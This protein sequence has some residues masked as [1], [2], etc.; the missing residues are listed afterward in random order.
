MARGFLPRQITSESAIG[1]ST[2]QKSIVIDDSHLSMTPAS[3]GN[4][5]VWTFSC[6]VKRMQLGA[7]SSMFSGGV[8]GGGAVDYF[9]FWNDDTLCFTNYNSSSYDIRTNAFFRDPTGWMHLVL[10][11]DSTQGTASNR[12]KIYVNGSQMTS[13][14]DSTYPSQNYDFEINKAVT[15]KIGYNHYNYLN[16][17]IAEVNF[18]DGLQLTP[19]SF[20]YESFQT[21]AWRPK[22]YEGAYGSNGYHLNFSDN[23]GVT[24]TTLGKDRSGQGNDFTST[25]IATRDSRLDSPSNN[26]CTFN[27]I[28]VNV[29]NIGTYE[30]G[31]L[32]VSMPSGNNHMRTDSTM[33]PSS[34][35]WYVELTFVSGYNS[36]D[37]TT[38]VGV[39]SGNASRA[40]S[41][42]DG[43]NQNNHNN[44]VAVCYQSGGVIKTQANSNILT[45]LPTF[46][47]GDILGIALDL[48]NDKFFCSKN[49]TFFSN[50]TG[51]Q[52]PVTGANPLYSGGVITSH[53]YNGFNIGIKGYSNQ[54]MKANYGADSTFSGTTTAGGFKD[55]G[56]IGD[57]KY[58]VPAGFKAICSNNFSPG[59]SGGVYNPK[60]HFNVIKYAGDGTQVVRGV[61]FEPGLVW[62]KNMN[63][64]H[65]HQWH[66]INRGPTGG[67]IRSNSSLSAGSSYL[68]DSFDP[69]GFTTASGNIT[70]VN[71]SGNDFTAACWKAGGAPVTNS[72]GTVSGSVSANPE[73]GFSIVKYTGSGGHV[74][75]GHGLGRKPK[76]I[77]SKKTNASG[78][79][80][81]NLDD[82]A[83][84]EIDED[85]HYI[86][87]NSTAVLDGPNGNIAP[88][89]AP[90]NS[91]AI[92]DTIYSIGGDLNESG[93]SYINYLWAEIPGYSRFGTYRG[94]NNT[95]GQYVH[96]GFRPA[97]VMV[98][99]IDVT[100]H[101]Y[102]C[103]NAR[104]PLNLDH[105]RYFEADD[106][107]G[108]TANYEFFDWCA[109]GF[110]CRAPGGSHQNASGN[111]ILFMAFAEN[112]GNSIFGTEALGT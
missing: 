38:H 100:S 29:N 111:R 104:D 101:W 65:H 50:G 108:G 91:A 59:S 31:N 85:R 52:D 46:Q 4:R 109:T 86:I 76:I 98:R 17:H 80:F 68:F 67:L 81:V 79:W 44:S 78:D 74:T 60:K 21:G 53:K 2:I 58:A 77:L 6:W 28:D 10:A 30:E 24:A 84:P 13:F 39:I 41:N 96:C 95:N 27:N 43:Y 51:T 89:V 5:R 83:F 47:N 90:D 22:K 25:G 26:F 105:K 18:V 61:G 110:K 82:T 106:T 64:T 69:D 7:Y 36:P 70:G 42:N 33:M 14:A 8:G 97:W 112:A 55:D 56:G 75:R 72:E 107:D 93:Q 63:D 99:N 62:V 9:L 16:G 20:A 12:V 3:N 87:L 48:D 45:G 32:K 19:T 34:G 49:G 66:D 103:D 1:G 54:T 57:F 15:Q 37:N 23:S 73:A 92:T 88:A 94:N 71:N 40:S 102:I 11:V 35:K